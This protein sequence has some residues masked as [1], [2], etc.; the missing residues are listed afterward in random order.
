ELDDA[1]GERRRDPPARELGGVGPGVPYRGGWGG[2]DAFDREFGFGRHASLLRWLRFDEGGEA[3]GAALPD[4]ALPG[5]PVLGGGEARG[6]DL[7]GAHTAALFGADQ[8]RRLE[9]RQ[10]LQKGGQA[11]REGLG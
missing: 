6:V 10:M 11:N 8:P 4:G 1:A 7:A 2:D 5:E 9:H 3:V